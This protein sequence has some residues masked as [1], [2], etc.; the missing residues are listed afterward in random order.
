MKR[1]IFTSFS[2]ASFGLVTAANAAATFY[3]NQVGYD[4]GKP[5]TVIVKNT[6][7][8]SGTAFSLLKDGIAVST[9]T[10]SVGANPD[11]WLSS[12]SFYTID[13]G[14]SLEAGTYMIQLADGSV[15]GA[16]TVSEYALATNTL[17]TVLDYFYEDRADTPYIFNLDAS[18][19]IYGSSEKR[20]VQGGWYDASGDV[21]KYLSHLSYANYLN[22]QQIPLSVWALAFTAKHIPTFLS[23]VSSVAKTDPETEAV[24]GADFLLRMLSPEGY[25]YMTVFDGWGSPSATR[26]ICAFSGSNGIKSAD[27]QT[28]FREGGGMAI[29]ALAKASTLAKDGDSTRAQYLAGAVRAFEHLQSKQ[30]MDGSCAYCDDGAENIIDDYTALLAATELFTATNEDS[31]LTA[32]RA[33]AKHLMDRLSDNGYFWSDDA[34][35][36]PFWHASDA[37]LP[38]IALI[39]YAEVEA[40]SEKNLNLKTAL[41]AIK[42]HY[43]W[44][45]KVTN[46]VDNP[47][48]YAR[49]TYKTGGTIKDGFFIPHDNES[50]YWWQGEDAR[51]ASLSAAVAY[52]AKVLNDV[53]FE[54]DKYATD[55]LDWILGKNPYAVCMMEGK[56]LKNPSVYNG[57]SSYDATLD[58]GIANGITGKNTDGSGIAWDSDGVGSVGFDLSESWQNWRWIEQWLPHTTWYLM[59]LATRYD[60]VS[61]DLIHTALPKTKS[62]PTFNIQQQ[63]R[64]LTVSLQ[65]NP[66]GK[67]LTVANLNGQKLY[68]ET[69]RSTQTTVNLDNLQDGVYFVQVNGLGSR[70]IL[71]K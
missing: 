31:Y 8:L 70:R 59:A 58:G 30:T 51:I 21:S 61:S 66:T 41:D 1:R 6:T 47:F 27:Y 11:S 69:L 33:R 71:L 7:D 29:A 48:G 22:P 63:G 40:S 26:E 37:G 45:L 9:G 2:L 39:R 3:Y 12:G 23:A 17:S 65:S 24:Y 53:N 49:Q 5:V 54:S 16:F 15:S 35:T 38:L 43:D 10:L 55:Q 68:R 56:G 50:G 44:L 18:I 67:V 42:K 62:A 25:F 57:Q 34:K 4:V 13:L 36:R 28:A 64:L 60:E 46:Q 19:G 20:N 32:A 52:A 14:P